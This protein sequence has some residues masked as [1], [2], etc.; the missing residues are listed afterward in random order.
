M[1]GSPRDGRAEGISGILRASGR[2][3]VQV[4]AERHNS[5]HVE[6]MGSAYG[7]KLSTVGPSMPWT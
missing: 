5:S 4:T 6:D 2:G 1:G 3:I 7:M